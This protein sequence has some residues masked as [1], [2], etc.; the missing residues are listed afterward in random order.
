MGGKAKDGRFNI[1]GGIGKKTTARSDLSAGTQSSEA[2]GK[3]QRKKIRREKQ[4]D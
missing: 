4:T 1:S 3:T 2:I